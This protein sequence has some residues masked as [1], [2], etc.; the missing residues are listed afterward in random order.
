MSVHENNKQINR[1]LILCVAITGFIFIGDTQV[2]LGVAGGVPYILVILLSLWIDNH[3]YTLGLAIICTLLTMVGFYASP[4]GSALWKV[5]VNRFLAVF[6]IWSVTIL[7]LQR[8][9]IA[10]EKE[11]AVKERE[12]ALEDIRVLK[13]LIPICSSCKKIRDEQGHWNQLEA[14]ISK[15]SEADF[16]HGICPDCKK[17]LYPELMKDK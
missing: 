5:L 7:S 1:T 12:R 2:P 8:K 14:Y 17:A 6:A 15:N 16:S 9:T 11:R 13:G 4:S 3:R 10:E